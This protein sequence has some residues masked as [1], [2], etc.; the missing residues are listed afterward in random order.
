MVGREAGATLRTELN[1]AAG[2][3]PDAI[4]VISW[5][6]FSE[7]TFIEPSRA[8]GSTSLKVIAEARGARPPDVSTFDSDAAGTGTTAFG[9][10]Y[11]IVGLSVGCLGLL[12]LTVVARR[13]RRPRAVPLAKGPLAR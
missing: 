4:G 7:N 9:V 12:A 13:R 3:S 5:N 11:G 1:V 10:S 8:Y 2:S 6:E